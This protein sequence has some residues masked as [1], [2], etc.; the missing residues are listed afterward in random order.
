MRANAAWSYSLTERGQSLQ[1]A[2]V[3]LEEWGKS[4]LR[5]AKSDSGSVC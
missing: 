5:P 2:V 3:A 4:Y 1:P